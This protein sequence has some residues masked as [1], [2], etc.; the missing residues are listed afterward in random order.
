LISPKPILSYAE[1]QLGE[2]SFN[3]L[4]LLPSQSDKYQAILPSFDWEEEN[5]SINPIFKTPLAINPAVQKSALDNDYV[6]LRKKNNKEALVI[7]M[8]TMK[9]KTLPSTLLDKNTK[10][11]LT[12]AR[13]H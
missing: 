4:F 8:K 6:V 2:N 12:W 11:I 7:D 9:N 13:K 3:S 1:Y 10:E 5:F